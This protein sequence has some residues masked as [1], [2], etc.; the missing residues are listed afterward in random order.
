MRQLEDNEIDWQNVLCCSVNR[1]RLEGKLGKTLPEVLE[2]SETL[3]DCEN[4]ATSSTHKKQLK[5]GQ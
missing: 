1:K 5:I 4:I 3:P 2:H